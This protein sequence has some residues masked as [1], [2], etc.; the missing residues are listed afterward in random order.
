MQITGFCGMSTGL[1]GHPLILVAVI[2]AQLFS[3]KAFVQLPGNNSDF[4]VSPEPDE[5]T[6]L[7][8]VSY[9]D[10]I[11]TPYSK[12]VLPALDSANI[13]QAT[14]DRISSPSLAW[15]QLA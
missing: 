9:S 5:L 2:N 3:G 6:H 1:V 11:N 15:R 13:V 14:T 8:R 4:T 12:Q 7:V 10:S